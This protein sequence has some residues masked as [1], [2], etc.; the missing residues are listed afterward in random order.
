[1][2]QLALGKMEINQYRHW[3]RL[4]VAGCIELSPAHKVVLMTLADY[5]NRDSFLAWP[6]FDTLADNCDMDRRT[7]IRAINEGRRLGHI[8]KVR[9]G[10]R[11]LRPGG[12]GVS[13]QYAFLLRKDAEREDFGASPVSPRDEH[14]DILECHASPVGVSGVSCGSDARDTV[15]S[16]NTLSNTLIGAP[17]SS[18]GSD[19]HSS[20]VAP[21][22]DLTP[23]SSPDG[24][25]P[26]GARSATQQQERGSGEQRRARLSAEA[27]RA[28]VAAAFAK[29]EANGMDMSLSKRNRGNTVPQ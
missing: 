11:G 19:G 24:S 10:G 17:S 20:D 2:Q 28:Q 3:C 9:Q 23:N 5:L 21:S 8:K 12:H 13:N 25:V 26:S 22:E 6:D 29:L 7:V 4:K 27:R 16:E 14:N 15:Y 1:L 18:S